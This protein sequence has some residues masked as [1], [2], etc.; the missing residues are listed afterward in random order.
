MLMVYAPT[1]YYHWNTILPT[2]DFFFPV[3][4]KA[5]VSVFRLEVRFRVGERV[6][7]A[8]R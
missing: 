1:L 7:A 6:P 5:V 8:S 3:E 4:S 2:V